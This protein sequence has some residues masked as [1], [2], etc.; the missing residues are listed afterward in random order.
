VDSALP[1]EEALRRF[2]EGLPPVSRLEGGAPSRARLVEDFVRAVERGDG[3]ALRRMEITKG[4]F[5]Y[6]VYPSSIYTRPPYQEQPQILWLLQRA[7]GGS[8]FRRLMQRVAG[9]PLGYRGYRC[10]SPPEVQGANRL[11]GDCAVT[12]R[13]AAG[14]SV[15]GRLF[16]A[17]LERGGRFK[18]VSY[19]NDL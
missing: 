3:A 11:W 19:A 13:T 9:R 15:T 5:A 17:I 10:A 12:Y 7:K 4:E 6:L 18:F 2:R 8:G 16:G 14:D 1:A